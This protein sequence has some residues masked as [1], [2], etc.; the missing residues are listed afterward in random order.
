VNQ[1]LDRSY[2]ISIAELTGKHHQRDTWD[3]RRYRQGEV[4]T[5]SQKNL[6][7]DTQFYMWRKQHSS[8]RFLG[9]IIHRKQDA[10]PWGGGGRLKCS[11][12]FL[13][14]KAGLDVAAVSA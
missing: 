6:S 9:A 12:A 1:G 2:S 14:R 4:Q 10:T 11:N 7:P 13:L 5:N 3:G 8:N